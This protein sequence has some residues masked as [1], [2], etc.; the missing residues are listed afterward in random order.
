MNI[1]ENLYPIKS[2]SNIQS[3]NIKHDNSV[4]VIMRTKNRP[5]LLARALESVIQQ[6]YTNWHL[7]L[8]NDGGDAQ[9]VNQL[10]ELNFIDLNHKITIIHNTHSLGMEAASNCGFNIAN[11]EYLVVHDDDDAWHP[12]FLKETVTFLNTEQQAVAVLTNCTIINEEIQE[13]QS[14]QLST[15]QWPI[16][17]DQID[18]TTLIRNN[19]SPPI[20]LLIRMD[21]A[22]Q[23]G[24]FNKNLP[25]LGDWDYILRLF[26]AGEIKTLNKNLAY[27]YHRPNNNNTYGNSVI[28]AIDKHQKYHVEFRN[29]LVRQSILENQGNY[30]ILHILLND[31]KE[32][33][34]LL[35]H[36]IN[37]LDHKIGDIQGHVYYLR[38]KSFPLKRFAASIRQ[39]IRKWRHKT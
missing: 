37:Q 39:L 7:Y 10:I 30:G 13:D 27:Y 21:V 18:I 26:R 19:V 17:H 34:D 36:K 25:V 16:W 35:S 29:S 23:V 15:I 2:W 6:T 1:N 14:T 8:I 31:S 33:Y 38:R 11:Q 20:C 9:P 28:A 5:V 12:D 22:K 32:K 4:A 24:E 3:D